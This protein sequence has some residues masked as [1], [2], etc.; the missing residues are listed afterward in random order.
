MTSVS[1][2]I[3]CGV[4]V[5]PTIGRGAAARRQRTIT[6]GVSAPYRRLSRGSAWEAER[7]SLAGG[8]RTRVLRYTASRARL[9]FIRRRMTMA[10]AQITAPSVPKAVAPATGARTGG[11]PRIRDEG[12]V[13]Y[14]ESPSRLGH[15]AARPAGYPG[16]WR[17]RRPPRVSRRSTAREDR[18]VRVA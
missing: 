12:P 10:L 13:S 9:R 2:S 14:A 1:R 16:T 8:M 6:V 5:M 15:R 11:A 7:R 17:L 3:G 18:A 4:A